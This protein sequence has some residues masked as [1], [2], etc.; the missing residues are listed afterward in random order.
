MQVHDGL[1]GVEHVL[2]LLIG[3][4]ASGFVFLLILGLPPKLKD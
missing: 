3:F 1:I 4:K 2:P